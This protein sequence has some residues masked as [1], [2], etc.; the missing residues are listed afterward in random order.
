MA[1]GHGP[2]PDHL[3]HLAGLEE[4][5][6]NYHVFL[7]MRIVESAGSQGRPL[8]VT[9]RPNEDTVRIAQEPSLAYPPST[10]SGF[11]PPKD[12]VPGVLTNRFF[13]MFG[14]NGPLPLHLTEFARDR[15]VNERDRTFVAFADMLTH[16]LATLL[17]RAWKTGQPAPSFDR[18][19]DARVETKVA[20]LA[21]YHGR[22][23][24]QRDA[25]PDLAKR[26]FAGALAAG[27]RSP[28]GLVAMLSGFFSAPV[29]MREFVGCWLELEPDDQWH[30]G[31]AVG[32][33]QGT[34]VGSQVWSRAAKFRLSVGPLGRADYERLLPGGASL[35]RL[36][37][38][39]RNYVGDTLDW[40][41]NLVLKA[42][43][44]PEAQLGGD[45]R[46]GL[47]S[48]IGQRPDGRDADDLYV[49]PQ[50][51]GRQAA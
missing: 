2:R 43:D 46:L 34:N 50:T 42:D 29:G 5:P 51:T 6:W 15:L 13:G 23:L 38:I 22:E 25:M 33:G 44:V 47:T 14:P 18:G 16:R 4:Q 30:L 28:E 19:E 35:E 26:H 12:G 41:L 40:D 27:P 36:T 48:W 20:A 45:T 39:V 31:G 24:R 17:F 10:L 7:A 9:Q 3:N 21:G 49:S 37:A 32:L 11:V 8:G 1:S